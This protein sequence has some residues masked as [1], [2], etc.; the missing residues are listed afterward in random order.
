MFAMILAASIRTWPLPVRK[1]RSFGSPGMFQQLYVAPECSPATVA[2]SAAHET[3]TMG[4]A[5]PDTVMSQ[6]S[7]VRAYVAKL[8]TPSVKAQLS[9]CWTASH[10]DGSI[11][12]RTLRYCGILQSLVHI[13]GSGAQRWCV[14]LR[15]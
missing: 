15:P 13:A 1:H 10:A 2:G 3:G 5:R 8:V 7:Q 6:P 11:E 9:S 4:V 12:K 14:P